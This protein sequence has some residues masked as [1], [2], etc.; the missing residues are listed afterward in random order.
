MA[1]A[2][3]PVTADMNIKLPVH[4]QLQPKIHTD[5]YIYFDTPDVSNDLIFI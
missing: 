5:T 1:N 4:L 3:I 2:A